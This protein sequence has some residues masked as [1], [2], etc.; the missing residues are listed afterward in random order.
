MVRSNN[1]LLAHTLVVRGFDDHVHEQLGQIANQRG[2]SINSIVK[3]AVDKWLKKQGSSVP[4]K[5]HLVIYSDDES[6]KRMLKSMDRLAVEGKLF[7]CFFSPPHSYYTELMSKLNWY[8]G[9][10]EPYYYSPPKTI[11][12]QQL[13][14]QGQKS[15][16][17]YCGQVI[18]NVVKSAGDKQVCCMDF[19]LDEVKKASPKEALAIEKDYDSNRI[20]GLLYCAYKT[21]NLLGS[22]IEDLIEL[23][24]THDLVFIVKKE[25]VYQLH[26][27]KENIHKLFLS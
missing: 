19:L 27:T 21:D 25:E 5:H 26:I 17:E 16:T 4:R 3:D 24:E 20:A 18:E 22:E 15:I 11:K 8:N 2:V 7:R 12:E 6:I 13:H 9:T 14:I 10:V 1:M 23:F